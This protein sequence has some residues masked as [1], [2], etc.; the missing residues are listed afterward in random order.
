MEFFS[1]DALRALSK[2]VHS[3]AARTELLIR[4]VKPLNMIFT[5]SGPGY[6]IASLSLILSMSDYLCHRLPVFLGLLII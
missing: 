6:N 2:H 5:G 1:F 4:F 3:F